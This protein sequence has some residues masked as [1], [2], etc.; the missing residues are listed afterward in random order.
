[1]EKITMSSKEINQIEIF[2]KLKNRIITQKKAAFLLKLSERQVR[3]KFKRFSQMGPLGLI[4]CNRGKASKLKWSQQE[5]DQALLF[6]QLPEWK[7]F[8]PT[9]ASEKLAELHNIKISAETLRQVMIHEHLWKP[10]QRRPVYRQRRERKPC[11]GMLIQLDGSNHDWFEGRGSRCTLLVFIDDATSQ[12]VWLEFV[13]AES[14]Q[15]TMVATRSYFLKY[16]KPRAFYVDRASVFKVTKGNPDNIRLS[17]FARA[18]KE[19]D[20]EMSY[21]RS[22][23]AKGR[24]ERFNKTAQDRLIKEMRLAGINN[25]ESAN[26]FVKDVYIDKHNAQFSV[27]PANIHNEHRPVQASQLYDAFCLRQY[28]QLQ[29]DYTITYHRKIL[30]IEHQIALARPKDIITVSERIDGSIYLVCRKKL[31]Q[32]NE[33]KQHSKPV[34]EIMETVHKPATNHP[35]RVMGHFCQQKIDPDGGYFRILKAEIII[36]QKPEIITL[37]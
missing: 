29:N 20:V 26:N 24:V 30:Q 3:N 10:K 8:G 32:F 28:R 5:K 16:G 35:W 31:L 23:Q 11:F 22:P 12:V 33:I 17:N 37:V 27:L 21:A 7:D 9:F 2:E 6:L 34:K 19:L 18:M 13:N 36:L 25:K 14:T 4:H 1:M 15:E